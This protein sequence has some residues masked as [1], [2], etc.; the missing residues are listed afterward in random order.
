M[1]FGVI[2]NSTFNVNIKSI[3]HFRMNFSFSHYDC[4]KKLRLDLL[5]VLL[6][7]ILTQF[8]I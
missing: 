3:K 1:N 8:D 2:Q 6:M 5:F 7:L 4:E